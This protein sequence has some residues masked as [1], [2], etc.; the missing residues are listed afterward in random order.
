MMAPENTCQFKTAFTVSIDLTEGTTTGI[1]AYD[2]AATIKAAADPACGSDAFA[3]PGHVFPLVA[4][5]GGVL[6]RAGHTEAAVDLARL[7][8][9]L[10][11]ALQG[12]E[13]LGAHG[14]NW[15]LHTHTARLLAAAGSKRDALPHLDLASRLEPDRLE[16][17]LLAVRYRLDLDDFE[18][19]KKTLVALSE[20]DSRPTASQSRLI[21][22]FQQRLEG[23]E[24]R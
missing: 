18:N 9:N 20:R 2:R 7:A 22:E 24:K 13:Q 12:A 14:K 16:A 4:T 19:A 1:S 3:R 8:G 10:H 21:E 15:L 6:R 11:T 17:G 23:I 5:S